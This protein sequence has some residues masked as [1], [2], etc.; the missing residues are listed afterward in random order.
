MGKQTKKK[1]SVDKNEG[2]EKR[3]KNERKETNRKDIER[4]RE[5]RVPLLSKIY[6]NRTVGFR[7][8]ES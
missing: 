5:K 7:Q 2:G 4:E 6:G 8:S 1:N 3:T